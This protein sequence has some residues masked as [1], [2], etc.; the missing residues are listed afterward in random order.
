MGRCWIL[1]ANPLWMEVYSWENQVQMDTGGCNEHT[2]TYCIHILYMYIMGIWMKYSVMRIWEPQ[3]GAHKNTFFSKNDHFGDHL[4]SSQSF[5]LLG[6]LFLCIYVDYHW[7]VHRKI[8][9]TRILGHGD[10]LTELQRPF[11]RSAKMLQLR[12][13]WQNP[14]FFLQKTWFPLFFRFV[15]NLLSFFFVFFSFFFLVFVFDSCCFLSFLNQIWQNRKV[16][17]FFSFFV[18]FFFIFFR[19]FS[20]FF[21]FF[22]LI[23]E[24][25]NQFSIYFWIFQWDKFFFWF[26]SDLKYFLS[27][28]SSLPVRLPQWSVRPWQDLLQQA[29]SHVLEHSVTIEN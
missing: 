2:H 28:F 19:C 15:F 29:K 11:S 10:E 4:K 13:S 26:F 25:R 21:P 16:A 12:Q 20:M 9:V 1:L 24:S 14:D 7:N 23:F 18:V 17:F 5:H 6:Q 3:A 22:R 8:T 27:L